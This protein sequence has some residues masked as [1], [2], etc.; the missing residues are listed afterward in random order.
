MDKYGLIDSLIM[1]IDKAADAHG[2]E[3][4]SALVDAIKMLGA[5]KDGLK[6]ED[7]AHDKRIEMLKSQIKNLA[8]PNP[9]AEDAIIGGGRYTIDLGVK[10]GACNAQEGE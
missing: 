1:L 4:C 2:I 10:E 5:L 8:G 9:E 3:R 6:N 7:S